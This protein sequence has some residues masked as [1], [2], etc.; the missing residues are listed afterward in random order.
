MEL[1]FWQIILIVIYAF[2]TQIDHLSFDLGFGR[3]IFAGFFAGLVLGDPVSGLIIG[4]TLQLLILGVGA[5]GGASVPDYTTAS[6][7]GTILG[8]GRDVNL[9]IALAI[10]VGLLLIQ[11]DILARFSN[12]YF[13]SRVDKYVL[14][15][16]I[17]GIKRMHLMGMLAWGL[18]R[19]IPVF[20]VLMLGQQFVDLVLEYI[21]QWLMSG[22]T[23]AGGLLPIVGITILMRYLPVKQLFAYFLLGF[24]LIAY[25]KISILGASLFGFVAAV[26]V[27]KSLSSQTKVAANTT[28]SIEKDGDYED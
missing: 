22:L 5:Y 3:P 25:L 12:T 23:T 15:A 7:I 1:A 16:N 8:A 4:G 20:L 24:L 28:S 9:A 6:I 27:F 2:F 10:P 19:A 11:L 17:P 14:E 21:P 26:L 18:S 13:Q